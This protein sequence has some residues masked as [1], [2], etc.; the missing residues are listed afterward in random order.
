MTNQEWLK[1]EIL[2]YVDDN[3]HQYAI[4]LEGEW[5]SGKTRFIDTVIAPAIKYKK[6]RLIKVSLFGLST[7]NDLYEA[8]GAAL[9]HM[10]DENDGKA[11]SAAKIGIAQI[12]AAL[13]AVAAHFGFSFSFSASMK[14]VVEL[15]IKEKHVFVF[16]DTE[17][18][19]ANS[20]DASLFGAINSLV[21]AKKAKVI[22]VSNCIDPDGSEKRSFDKEIRE[23]LVWHVYPFRPE[24]ATLVSD[25]FSGVDTQCLSVNALS[26]ISD[27]VRLAS[28]SNVRA[29]LR[30]ENFIRDICNVNAI[31]DESIP[32]SSRYSALRDAVQFALMKCMQ[33][34]PTQPGPWEGEAGFTTEY[35]AYINQGELYKKYSD[36]PCVAHYLNSHASNTAIDLDEEMRGYI[37]K[38][39]PGT[40]DSVRL[41]EIDKQLGMTHSLADDDVIPLISEFAAIVQRSK[42]NPTQIRTVVN[43]NCQLSGLGFDGLLSSTDLVECCQEVIS[44]DPNAAYD[45]FEHHAFAFDGI[46]KEFDKIMSKLNDCAKETYRES[47]RS[48]HGLNPAAEAIIT[49]DALAKK[50]RTTWKRSGE[51]VLLFSPELI[52]ETFA[53]SNPGEQEAIRSLFVTMD[54][55]MP[56]VVFT[57]PYMNWL[58]E[59]KTLLVDETE[60]DHTTKM[61]RNWFVSNIDS[62]LKRAGQ[63]ISASESKGSD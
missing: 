10:S 53:K 28:C 62:L 49:G 22:F 20:D 21:E 18:R 43:W 44:G 3:K 34:E 33:N 32:A 40:P 58:K 7:A 17:R 15:L 54:S 6:K 57:E 45:F 42:F 59:I 2:R 56:P 26:C 29:M 46:S 38:R 37:N 51:G 60:M 16:D 14:T 8:L 39:Y 63:N 48:H 1:D 50:M 27:G 12:P 52:V 4:A 24:T 25:I 30:A 23:K 9:I 47:V 5:G 61:R 35:V 41:D 36:F 13:K 19:A 11:A 31:R 55:I